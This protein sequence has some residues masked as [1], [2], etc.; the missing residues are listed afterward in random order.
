V[1][2]LG[3]APAVLDIALGAA[4]AAPSTAHPVRVVTGGAPPPTRTIARVE[5]ELGWEV[6]QIYG[7]TET[8]PVLAITS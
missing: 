7:L 5:R 6:I 2:L 8:S 4:D 1:T 3:G